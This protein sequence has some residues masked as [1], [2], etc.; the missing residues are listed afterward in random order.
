MKKY[1]QSCGVDVLQSIV[2]CPR[3]GGREYRNHSPAFNVN[4]TS[5]N[6]PKDDK[7]NS[8]QNIQSVNQQLLSVYKS[9]YRIA[10]L[11]S[12]SNWALV[13]SLLG[14]AI[15]NLFF[16][17]LFPTS[18]NSWSESLAA[19]I[20][21]I[22][23]IFN[24]FTNTSVVLMLIAFFFNSIW[25]YTSAKTIQAHTT[26]QLKS[27]PG[28][29]VGWF[30]VPIAQLWKPYQAIKSISNVSMKLAGNTEKVIPSLIFPIWWILYLLTILL[31][32]LYM[33]TFFGSADSI[34]D[35]LLAMKVSLAGT[36]I[37]IVATILFNKIMR[38]IHLKQMKVAWI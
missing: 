7:H 2:I 21:L 29:S 37:F 4:A 31:D 19:Q 26:E 13:F 23:N 27:S 24:F 34:D 17:K 10:L 8:P 15:S 11:S 38:D 30:F 18:V 25:I 35:L 28:W 20:E 22:Q 36:I 16:L 6:N 1:C 14:S 9:L 12:I 32:R 5:G 33:K 3:C